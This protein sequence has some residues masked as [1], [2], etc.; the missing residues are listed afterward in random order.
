MDFWEVY[1][2]FSPLESFTTHYTLP[3]CYSPSTVPTH[4]RQESSTV[5]EE[6]HIRMSGIEGR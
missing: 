1:S 5:Y 4:L 2:G 6:P 3:T